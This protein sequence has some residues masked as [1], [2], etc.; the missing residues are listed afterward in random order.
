MSAVMDHIKKKEKFLEIVIK[1][2]QEESLR[3]TIK[4][5]KEAKTDEEYLFVCALADTEEAT[6][7]AAKIFSHLKEGATVMFESKDEKRSGF[8]H[9]GERKTLDEVIEAIVGW[10][11]CS[12]TVT[13]KLPVSF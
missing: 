4:K 6:H 2:A 10:Q 8:A 12:A 7:I 13:W 9:V 1:E 11:Q 5:M 3:S